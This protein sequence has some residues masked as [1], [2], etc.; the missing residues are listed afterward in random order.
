MKI[1]YEVDFPEDNPFSNE[2]DVVLNDE[3]GS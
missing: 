2:I 1:A 3:F